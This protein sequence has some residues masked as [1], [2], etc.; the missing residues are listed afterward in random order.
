MPGVSFEFGVLGL[1]FWV[2]GLGFGVWSFGIWGLEF[3]GL[4]FE[5]FW[6]GLL[7][8]GFWVWVLGGLDVI[9]KEA[10]SFYRTISGVRLYWELEEPKVPEGP[11]QI[12]T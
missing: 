1:D 3:W 5:F 8:C 7:G 12:S 4:G 10:W 11:R 2:L 6:F 9:R